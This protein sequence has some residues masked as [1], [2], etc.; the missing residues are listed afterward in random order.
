MDDLISRAQG[1]IDSALTATENLRLV[2]SE[3]GLELLPDQCK[4]DKI[5]YAV[6]IN[7][8]RLL[9]RGNSTEEAHERLLKKITGEAN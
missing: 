2:V 1:I 5:G 9:G 6:E 3:L 7:G 4:D 8:Q